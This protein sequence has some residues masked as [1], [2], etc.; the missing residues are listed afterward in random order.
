[1][2]D[3]HAITD[4]LGRYFDGLYRS[5]TAILREVFDPHAGYY[6]VTEGRLLYL[7]MPSYFSVV[8]ARP[9]PASKG[10][11]RTDRILSIERV[12][13]VTALARVQCAIAPQHFT[14]L[15]SLLKIDDRWRIVSKVFHSEIHP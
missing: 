10:Q 12:G 6:T 13:A 7:D 5:D 4:M 2:S 9:S 14:D 11:A 8:D 3:L 15:L 1:M